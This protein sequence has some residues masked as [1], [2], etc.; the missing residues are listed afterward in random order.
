M[1]PLSGLITP[2]LEMRHLR[3]HMMKKYSIIETIRHMGIQ[4][5]Q[6][7][8]WLHMDY[9]EEEFEKFKDKMHH[10]KQKHNEMMAHLKKLF[11]TRRHQI[12]KLHIKDMDV[13]IL[14]KE[15]IRKNKISMEEADIYMNEW[16]R[17]AKAHCQSSKLTKKYIL[18]IISLLLIE[19]TIPNQSSA[20]MLEM[21]DNQLQGTTGKSGISI[22]MTTEDG[23]KAQKNLNLDQFDKQVNAFMDTIKAKVDAQDSN[24]LV[25]DME[26]L[27]R[28]FESI[29]ISSPAGGV[30]VDNLRISGSGSA[31]I[32]VQ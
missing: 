30:K 29:Q 5:N 6:L 3:R 4:Q 11:V 32:R 24:E 25:I 17:Y 26:D 16:F 22:V 21:K 31:K 2:F 15:L 1:R 20:E 8:E 23:N 9:L 18:L 19:S 7:R 28:D 10:K 27:S 12:K 14:F 13:I